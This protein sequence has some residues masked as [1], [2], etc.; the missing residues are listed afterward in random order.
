M[1]QLCREQLTLCREAAA[2]GVEGELRS[3]QGL[4]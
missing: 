3:E 4:V 1:F 2:C